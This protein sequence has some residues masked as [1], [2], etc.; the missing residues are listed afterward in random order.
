MSVTKDVHRHLTASDVMTS[1]V[2]S[3][4]LAATC[5]RW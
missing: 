5:A 3:V 2:V 1:P 4:G